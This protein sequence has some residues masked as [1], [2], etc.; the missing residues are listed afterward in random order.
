MNGKV[1]GNGERETDMTAN[2][3]NGQNGENGSRAHVSRYNQGLE[4]PAAG[5]EE[6]DSRRRSALR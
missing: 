5:V 3:L 2:G 6:L 1:A 4:R